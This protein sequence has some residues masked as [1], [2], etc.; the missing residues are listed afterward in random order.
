M[1]I[2]SFIINVLTPHMSAHVISVFL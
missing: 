1:K 2:F